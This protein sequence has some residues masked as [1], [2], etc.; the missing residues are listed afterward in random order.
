[1][2]P[3]QIG[4]LARAW[5][6]WKALRL[7][8]RRRLFVGHDLEGNTYWEFRLTS[9]A[10]RWRRIVHYP[11]S[12]HYSQVRVSP[13]WHQWLRHMRASPPSLD[14]QRGDVFR[15]ERLKHLAAEA[16]AR[17][18]A[19]PRVVEPP[20]DTPRL[21]SRPAQDQQQQPQQQQQQQQP[22]D[23]WAGARARARAQGP[24]E[25]WQPA[26]W[27]PGPAKGP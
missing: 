23:P 12:T 25:A 26:A 5:Y 3:K 8:W 27:N 7:P 11:R 14:E 13:L 17:W 21:E 2:P 20:R 24:G 10:S 15:Q 16:D 9:S 18:E 4:P 6:K 19:K 1:M 22:G